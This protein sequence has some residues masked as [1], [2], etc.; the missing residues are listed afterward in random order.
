[1]L[2]KE[3]SQLKSENKWREEKGKLEK[4]EFEN[5]R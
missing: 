4:G 3:K 1:M 5:A 2:R